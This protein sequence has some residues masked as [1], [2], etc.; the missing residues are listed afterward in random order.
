MHHTHQAE[1][2]QGMRQLLHHHAPAGLMLAVSAAELLTGLLKQSVVVWL[3][4]VRLNRRTAPSPVA[5][6]FN[7]LM[8]AAVLAVRR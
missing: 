5:Q 6:P 8:P 4:R 2:N 3:L 7:G 1:L